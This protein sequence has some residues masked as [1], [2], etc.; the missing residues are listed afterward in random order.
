[1]KI[2]TDRNANHDRIL[3]TYFPTKN[4][5]PAQ[6]SPPQKKKIAN[7]KIFAEPKKN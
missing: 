7:P 2:L 3:I 5:L 1:M 4:Y 6:N